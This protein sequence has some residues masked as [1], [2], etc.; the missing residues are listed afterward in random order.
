MILIFAVIYVLLAAIDVLPTPCQHRWEL[1]E[2]KHITRSTR[3]ADAWVVVQRCKRWGKTR[4]RR[5]DI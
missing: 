4:V 3:A 1:I 5:Y 2:S